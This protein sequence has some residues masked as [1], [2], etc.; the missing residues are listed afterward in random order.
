MQSVKES[1]GAYAGS[2]F[3][4]ALT[5]PA[6]TL[7]RQLQVTDRTTTT[8]QLLRGI[9]ARGFHTLYKGLGPALITQPAYWSVYTPV[10]HLLQR[11][12]S[13]E[14]G[15]SAGNM[16]IAW[17]A[18]AFAT[19]TTNPIW[20]LR[21]RMQTEIVKGKRQGYGSLVKE[22]YRENGIRT[23]FRGTSI[24]L[25]KNIQMAALLPL[26]EHWKQ[27]PPG[28]VNAVLPAGAA[29][30]ASAGLAKVVSSSWLYPLDVLRTNIRYIEG[31]DVTFRKAWNEVK[32]RAGIR[33]VV[34]GIGWYW[35]SSA[36]TFAAMMWVRGLSD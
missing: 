6:D 15:L 11:N 1:V 7:S 20:V 36:G 33:G 19:V 14:T 26:F 13:V 24:T 10:Y 5:F 29:V 3:G 2:A 28:F 12:T 21:Q 22:L 30:I 17:S 8:K 32:G 25:V 27:S 34:R 16:A 35:L 31:K 4:V 18:G 9:R 23:F